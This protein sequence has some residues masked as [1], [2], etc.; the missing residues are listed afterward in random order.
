MKPKMLPEPVKTKYNLQWRPIF[1]LIEQAPDLEMRETKIDGE[2]IRSSFNIA[3]EYLKTRVEYCFQIPKR[4]QWNG[5]YHIGQRRWRPRLFANMERTRINHT[6][7]RSYRIAISHDSSTV[8]PSLK[9]RE[10]ECVVIQVFQLDVLLLLELLLEQMKQT[11]SSQ[12]CVHSFRDVQELGDAK[13]TRKPPR[14]LQQQYKKSKHT[15]HPEQQQETEQ[16]F[17]WV[18][19]SGYK[20]RTCRINAFRVDS[21]KDFLSLLFSY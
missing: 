9:Q 2:H 8:A 17:T 15:I 13:S 11:G 6:F 21:C 7:P 4:I 14:R 3:K 18:P 16:P 5:R 19:V 12:T 20:T 1:S 10:Q